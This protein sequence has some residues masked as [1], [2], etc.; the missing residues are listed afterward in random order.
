MKHLLSRTSRKTD[1]VIRPDILRWIPPRWDLFMGNERIIRHF[2]RLVKKIRRMAE[3]GN[4]VDLNKLCF[5]LV[6]DSRSGKTALIK[7]LVRCLVCRQFD[8]VTLN[9]CSGTCP[10]CRQS[11]E[12]SGLAGVHA[13]ILATSEVEVPVHFVVFDCT[14]IHT[15]EQLRNHLI[16]VSN[17]YEGI[18]IFYFDE[19]HRLIR[20]GMDEML[21]KA[22]EEKQA[23]W[24][25]STA[26][27][28]GLEDM[29]QNRLLKLATQSPSEVDLATWL[30]DRCDEWGIRWEPEAVYR[31]AEKSNQVVGTALHALALASLDDDEGLTLDL[32]END[33]I[34]KLDN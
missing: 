12:E 31:V 18:R 34:V 6:G 3:G 20:Q 11:P 8:P 24:F 33:W 32:V 17:N 22:V 2:K 23:I 13:N 7:T 25:F 28:E 9:H 1:A 16:S 14:M 30:A 26:K 10:A 15:P 19:V 21:L 29:F 4:M 27:P 5:L